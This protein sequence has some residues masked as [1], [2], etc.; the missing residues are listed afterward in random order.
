M[1]KCKASGLDGEVCRT[2][3]GDQIDSAIIISRL[4]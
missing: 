2:I 3:N 1:E 4:I